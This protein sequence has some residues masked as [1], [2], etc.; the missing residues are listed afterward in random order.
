MNKSSEHSN[1]WSLILLILFFTIFLSVSCI[2]KLQVNISSPVQPMPIDCIIPNDS[3][4]IQ[5]DTKFCPGVYNLPNGIS[6]Q[7]NVML[8]CD[9][10]TLNGTKIYRSY[11]I[12]IQ[13]SSNITLIN[14]NVENYYIG[15]ETRWLTESTIINNNATNNDFGAYVWQTYNSSILQNKFSNNTYG[16]RV[17]TSGFNI[18]INNSFTY[19]GRYGMES[20]IGYGNNITLN[21]LKDNSQSLIFYNTYYFENVSNNIWDNDIWDNGVW[22]ANRNNYCINNISN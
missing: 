8:N 1:K 19:N 12:R 3:M 6:V 18:I 15:Y 17:E 14:C 5:I 21:W 9:G 7:N 20:D 16:M 22:E 10:A 11:G 4:Q 13:Q 2:A